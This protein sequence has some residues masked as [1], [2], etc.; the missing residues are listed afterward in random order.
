M[1][2]PSPLEYLTTLS[3]ASII[4]TFQADMPSDGDHDKSLGVERNEGKEQEAVR[5]GI[6][7]LTQLSNA[8]NQ[9]SSN[10]SS[11]SQPL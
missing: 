5:Q 7:E 10:V 3:I 2:F 6:A 1:R 4:N 8:L 11:D 9:K